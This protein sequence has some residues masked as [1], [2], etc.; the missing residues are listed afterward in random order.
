[1]RAA[2]ADTRP[3]SLESV[4]I[5]AAFPVAKASTFTTL[6][7]ATIPAG[8]MPCCCIAQATPSVVAGGPSFPPRIIPG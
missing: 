6:A 8:A 5:P 3:G 2:I 4:Q 1:M 7:S